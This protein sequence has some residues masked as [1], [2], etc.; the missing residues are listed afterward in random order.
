MRAVFFALLALTCVLSAQTTIPTSNP[1]VAYAY[2]G[3]NLTPGNIS[4][5]AIHSNG[6]ISGVSG[7]PFRGPAQ[8]LA[9][10]S[11]Y[12]F[13]TDQTNFAT[14]TRLPTGALLLSSS[15]NGVAHN[16]T[17]TDSLV[18]PIT[19]DHTGNSLYAA[20]FDFQG[21]D[22]NAYAGF[23]VTMGGKLEFSSNTPIN[24]F[25]GSSLQF[26]QDNKFVYGQS[27]YHLFWVIPAFYREASGQ[28]TPFDPG[29][30]FP[31][32]SGNETPCPD[33]SAVSAEGYLAIAYGNLGETIATNHSIEV[34]R[35]TASGALKFVSNIQTNFTGIGSIRFDPTGEY[36]A[37][38][39]QAGIESF[40]LNT[41][42]TLTL[43]SVPILNTTTLSSVQWDKTG[44]VYAISSGAL[45]VFKTNNGIMSLA[46]QP[47][48]V[49]QPQSLAV[50][51]AQ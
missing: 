48:A 46:S 43:L 49:A 42:G 13:G 37:V 51:P 2:L 27:C 33:A 10:D 36:L 39:G 15:V 4:A 6:I 31:P 24:A 7:S 35:I 34:F 1:I 47:V 5:F 23:S 40:R 25:D 21:P 11:G 50:L 41:N 3:E 12:V 22:N 29:N 28:L 20:E 9:V 45:Y 38:A 8:N 16:D 19:L 26:S 32:N 18:G 14:Y 44:H 17:P 30:T